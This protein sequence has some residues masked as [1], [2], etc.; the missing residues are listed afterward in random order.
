MLHEEGLPQ[1]LARHQRLAESVR[2]AVK[3]WGL[4]ILCKN[5]SEYS[6][7]L[8][9][10][11]LPENVDTEAVLQA[12]ETHFDLSLGTGLGRVRGR[13]FRIGHLGAL[14]ELEVL[15]TVGGVEMALALAGVRVPMGA[16]VAACQQFLMEAFLART[17][18]R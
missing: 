12:A 17:T 3:A 15:A 18:K 1:V 5:P 11:V 8:T 6:N 10:V 7:T 14:N 4:E 13:V 2:R 16:G 9:A